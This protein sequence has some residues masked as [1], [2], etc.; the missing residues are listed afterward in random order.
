MVD[1]L[2]RHVPASC[3]IHTSKRLTSYDVNPKT[4]KIT[5]RFSDGSSSVTDVLIGADGIRSATRRTMYQNLA[6]SVEDDNSK[7]K[8]FEYIDPVWTGILVYRSLIPTAKLLK[9]YP[10][11]EP[12]TELTLV[13]H[14]AGSYRGNTYFYI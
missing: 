12:P 9:K 13:S 14:L 3:K 1:F 10:D 8:V 6:S 5:L 7:K 11:V 2:L 4:G